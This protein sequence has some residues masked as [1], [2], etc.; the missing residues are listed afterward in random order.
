MARLSNIK[1]AFAGWPPAQ[2]L[3][4][5]GGVRYEELAD[6]DLAH[7]ANVYAQTMVSLMSAQVTALQ[8]SARLPRNSENLWPSGEPALQVPPQIAKCR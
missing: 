6:F 7:A 2:Q 8:V 4:N 5:R 1:N 3:Q